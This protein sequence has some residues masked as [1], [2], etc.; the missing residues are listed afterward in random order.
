MKG[1]NL[2]L[3]FLAIAVITV[4]GLNIKLQTVGE[5]VTFDSCDS[6]TVSNGNWYQGYPD[7]TVLTIDT[8][9]KI[10]GSG[11]IALYTNATKSTFIYKYLADYDLS[12]TPFVRFRLKASTNPDTVSIFITIYAL[13][14]NGSRAY[15]YETLDYIQNNWATFEIDLRQPL[16][17]TPDLTSVT[18]LEFDWGYRFGVPAAG[19][20]MKIDWIEVAPEAGAVQPLTVNVSPSSTT[21]TLG[22]SVSF[23]ASASGG[24]TP[25]TYSWSLNG[26]PLDESSSS[27]TITPESPGTYTV[28]CT[29]TDSLGSTASASATLTVTESQQGP[30]TSTKYSLTVEIEGNGTT[31]PEPGQYTFDEGA[32]VHLEAT[33]SQGWLFAYWMINGQQYNESSVTLTMNKNYEAIAYFTE[34]TEPIP[35]PDH[36]PPTG[37]LPP[38]EEI[39]PQPWSENLTLIIA[40][41]IVGAI[42]VLLISR[43]EKK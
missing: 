32:T 1:K 38:P 9:D 16:S 36:T 35:L 31:S 21:I 40:I 11:C 26:E 25:Y 22:S 13:T 24:I 33:P 12:Q 20:V 17:G 34:I 39:Q 3:L 8:T 29:I 4:V 6:L 27:V 18:V 19:E 28:S 30:P 41:I 14:E 2:I 37:V 42:M 43:R 15:G 7:S 5:Y 10:E 23:S